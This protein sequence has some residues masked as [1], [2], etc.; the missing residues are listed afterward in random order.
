MF[1]VRQKSNQCGLHAIQNM[2]K[3]AAVTNE[4]MHAAC[5]DIHTQTGDA[6]Q[7][8]ESFGGDWSVSA[9]IA[10]V[11][12]RGYSVEPAVSSKSERTWSST[13]ISELLKD[14]TFRGMIVHQ[15]LNRHF[16]C[17]RPETVDGVRQ[18]F[19]VDSQ[20]SGPLRISPKLATR[21]CLAAAY[22]WEPYIVKGEVMEF[23]PNLSIQ[24][25]EIQRPQRTG[26][27]PP[28]DFM[29]AWYSL[30]SKQQ[31]TVESKSPMGE[32]TM[33]EVVVDDK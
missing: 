31:Q 9:V 29:Q 28:E 20:S 21:R 13:D 5:E 10:A 18:L 8:H 14:K 32:S 27:R 25:P 24:Q 17:L 30:P 3:S 26:Q 33:E 19:Y 16:T 15:P 6:V 2:F 7:N 22:A 12:R 1:F 11:V 23:V 4:D